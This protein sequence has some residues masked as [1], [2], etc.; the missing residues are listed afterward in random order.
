VFSSGSRKLFLASLAI[1]GAVSGLLTATALRAASA[2]KDTYE[3]LETFAGIMA[4]VQR[5]YVDE[6]GTKDL[7]EGAIRGMIASLDPHSAYLTP[8]GYKELQIETRGEFG[9]L[10]IELTVRDSILTIVTPI[11]DTPAFRAGIKPGDQIIKIDDDLSVELPLQQAVEKM[12]GKPGT[13]VR[14][15][16]KRKGVSDLIDFELTR[17]VIHIRSVRGS[18]LVDGRY[19]YVRLTGFQEASA[20]E[21]GEALAKLD[22]Q[23]K[24]G[25]EGIVLDLRY[26][27]GGLLNQAVSVTDLFLD[28]GLVVRID[29]RIE[30]QSTKFFA[31]ADGTR[32]AVPMVILI[33]E[34][35]ASASEIV[36]GALQDH[37]RALIVGSRSFG[38]GSVQTILP[39]GENTALRL[40]TARYYT[41]SGR[42][43][44]EQGIEPD[45]VVEMDEPEPLPE[46]A[47]PPL[48]S[49][50]DFD[51]D[52]DA[53]LRKAFEMI[54]TWRGDIARIGGVA[55][56]TVPAK[57]AGAAAATAK[58]AARPH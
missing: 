15:S 40:T 35:S 34:G 22:R 41:P 47:E 18:R 21:L 8:E 26:N 9:G 29:G 1:V 11:D 3:N 52:G 44:H 30:N 10:G 5:H 7:V 6:V 58:S 20:T 37:E 27:P 33:N 57:T 14:L 42:S 16:I 46:G 28:A 51:I 50:D 54:R 43:I 23:G 25:V 13:K 2:P 17:E 39:L 24:G 48:R 56:F 38:K 19:A 55:G 53:Q 36:A 32:R 4:I 45:V 31:Q 12:R 49:R